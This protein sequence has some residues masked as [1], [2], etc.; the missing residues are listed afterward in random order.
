MRTLSEEELKSVQKTIAQRDITSA[1]LLMEVYDHFISHLEEFPEEDFEEQLNALNEKWSYGYCKK[2]QHDLSKNFNKS[3]R[4]TLWKLIKSY[5]TGP[6]IVFTLLMI[7]GITFLAN[8]LEGKMQGMVLIM[9][10]VIFIFLFMIYIG[11]SE[12][13]RLRKIK[14]LFKDS[15]LKISSTFNRYFVTYLLLPISFFN[16]GIYLPKLFGTGNLYSKS[17]SNYLIATF[18]ICLCLYSISAYQTW[19]IKSKT[20]LL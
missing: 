10:A 9:P 19:K 18:C 2:L 4:T 15:G 5:F 20:A 14:Q 12:F 16:L 13:L 11:V 6:K 3:I 17:L 7:C 8:S 1:E